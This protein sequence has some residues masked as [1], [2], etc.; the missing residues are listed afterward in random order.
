MFKKNLLYKKFIKL[1]LPIT[2]IIESFFNFFENWKSNKKKYL[3]L[4]R[5]SLEKKTF[6]VSGVTFLA[7]ITYF[8]IPAFYN[9]NKIKAQLESHIL[10]KYNLEVKLDKNPKYSLLP[11]PHFLATD[12]KIQYD[13]KTISNSQNIQFFISSKNNFEINKVKLKN[14]VFKNTEFK[15]NKKNFRFFMNLL[16]NKTAD[17]DIKFIKSKLF[18]LDQDENVIFFSSIK[19]LD[20]SYKQN[21]LNEMK[22]NLEVFNLP[23]KLKTAHD[24]TKKNIFTKIYLKPLKLKIENNID[25]NQNGLNGELSFNYINNDKSISYNLKN[26]NLTF[27]TEDKKL[28]GEINIKPFFLLSNLDLQNI[29]IKEIYR[30]DSIMINL[31]KSEIFNNRNL[32]GK[33]SVSINSLNDLRNIG[34]IKFD[35]QFEEGSIFISNLNFLFK[36][37]KFNFDDVRLVIDNNQLKFIGDMIIDFKDME[38]FYSHF[39]IKRNYR[40]N[41]DRINSSFVFNFDD[42]LFELNEL[43]IKDVDKQIINKFLNSFNSKEKDFFNKVTI[44]NTVRDFFRIISSG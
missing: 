37:T 5:K 6:I 30:N 35:I 31:L 18:Y 9:E 44:R 39:Q 10:K 4:W 34:V 32:N 16:N 20:Y 11:K 14:I 33:L 42:K 13:S 8:L 28:T 1:V 41:I 24:T 29:R 19:K 21:L 23:I 26:K 25:Y 7:V 22:S 12:V 15:I 40:K 17:Q 43:K 38:D 27:N 3:T 2:K 36:G